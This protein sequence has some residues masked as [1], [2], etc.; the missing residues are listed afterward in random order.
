MKAVCLAEVLGVPPEGILQA[1]SHYVFSLPQ[2]CLMTAA[3]WCTAQEHGPDIRDLLWARWKG[4][5]L[6][7][8]ARFITPMAH[9]LQREWEKLRL[10]DGILH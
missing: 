5:T 2:L 10:L 3:K 9:L 8:F 1:W 7:S 4:P 6:L